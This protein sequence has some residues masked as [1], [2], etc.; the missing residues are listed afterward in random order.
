VLVVSFY[1]AA[2][3]VVISVL[4]YIDPAAA[5][6]KDSPVL[7]A[8]PSGADKVDKDVEIQ[9]SSG[10]GSGSGSNS[11]ILPSSSHSGGSEDG[12]NITVM[13]SKV[14]ELQKRS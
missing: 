3:V 9:L 1:Q 4:L 2:L 14:S 7:A 13:V 5:V 10:S 11:P 8:T 12:D 6:P